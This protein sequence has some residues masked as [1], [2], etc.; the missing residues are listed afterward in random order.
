MFL[1]ILNFSGTTL[2]KIGITK[3]NI[4]KRI[5]EL[6]TGSPYKID[7]IWKYKTSYATKIEPVIHRHYS[8]CNTKGEWFDFNDVN[9][10]EVKTKILKI[11]ENIKFLQENE[12]Q[13][14]LD[15][16]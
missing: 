12:K 9:I 14:S 7:E 15:R 10:E 2:Y 3:N 13:K 8:H 11:E 4:E 6:Q 5:S 1:Y 16:Y